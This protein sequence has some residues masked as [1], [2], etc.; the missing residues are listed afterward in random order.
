LKK[1][2]EVLKQGAAVKSGN[3]Y[4]LLGVPRD[5]RPHEISAA[6][7]EILIRLQRG[8]VSH[9]SRQELADAYHTL[10]K[11]DR[12]AE[13]DNQLPEGIYYYEQTQVFDWNQ[14]AGIVAEALKGKHDEDLSSQV[15]KIFEHDSQKETP[16]NCRLCIMLCHRCHSHRSGIVTGVCRSGSGGRKRRNYI[17]RNC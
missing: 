16:A 5:A 13:Y 15:E 11:P 10:S 17:A 2:V 9:H 1:E 14:H 4:Q 8:E 12:R 7:K 3:Y 6:Y